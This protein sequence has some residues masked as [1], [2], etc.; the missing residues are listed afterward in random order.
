MSVNRCTGLE[1]H[2]LC[3]APYK[4][5]Y[6]CV[7]DVRLLCLMWFKHCGVNLDTDRTVACTSMGKECNSGVVWGVHCGAEVAI[8]SSLLM[9]ASL[10][11]EACLMVLPWTLPLYATHSWCGLPN[12][13]ANTTGFLLL[14]LSNSRSHTYYVCVCVFELRE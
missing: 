9:F 12:S 7:R 8:C 5:L 14:L 6:R 4:R 1:V 2:F 11:P 3:K 13:V 10:S